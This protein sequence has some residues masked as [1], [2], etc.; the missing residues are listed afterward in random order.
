[1]AFLSKPKTLGAEHTPEAI[2][3]RLGQGARQN[4]LRDFVYGG[5][6]GVVTTF[7][8]VA[9]TIGAGLS[10]NV[11]LILGGANLIADGFS[12]AS[13]NFLGTKAE[14]EDLDRLRSLEEHHIDTVP[15]GEREEVK[16]IYARKG[17][18]GADLERVVELLTSDRDRWVQTMLTE[19]YG[20]PREIRSEWK[21]AIMTFSA[22]FVCG[23]VPLLPFVF[24]TDTSFM[25][26]ILLTGVVF[27]LIGSAKSFWSTS[28]WQ[29]SG[30]VTLAVGGTAAVLA[31]F[32]GM[33]LRSIGG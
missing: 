30:A 6:D 13:A 3:H 28:S 15:E 25:V 26:S 17:F 12:M 20:L 31:Y 23:L 8:V 27:F 16:Q 10:T 32:V 24:E 22:F 7:A 14:K 1:M 11:I 5:I 9:G 2:R 29:R 4:Y 18:E 33:L 19:E 21:A